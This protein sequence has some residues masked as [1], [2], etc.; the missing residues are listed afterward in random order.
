MTSR[1]ATLP[2]H[3]A[4]LR[5]RRLPT[6]LRRA[7]GPDRRGCTPRASFEP[8]RGTLSARRPAGRVAHATAQ[9]PSLLLVLLPRRR[10][11]E[12]VC[13][14]HQVEVIAM[15]DKPRRRPPPQLQR[16]STGCRHAPSACPVARISFRLCWRYF[17]PLAAGRELAVL[18]MG[19][20]RGTEYKGT[21]RRSARRS[22]RATP[23]RA[24]TALRCVSVLG[25]T[26]LFVCCD[27]LHRAALRCNTVERSRCR[28]PSGATMG[29]PLYLTGRRAQIDPRTVGIPPPRRPSAAHATSHMSSAPCSMFAARA[30]AGF[31]S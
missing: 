4:V 28:F 22:S 12:L 14:V 10:R 20:S 18:I 29:A 30:A 9:L 8:A 24:S 1:A 7:A 17:V 21:Q 5:I 27:A 6:A 15:S 19:Q 26:A 16:V 23:C 25:S 13:C 3:A 31:F 2:P 11:V